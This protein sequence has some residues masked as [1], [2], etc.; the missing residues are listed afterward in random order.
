MSE[1]LEAKIKKEKG[2]KCTV[3]V[4]PE[5]VSI[6]TETPAD[7]YLAKSAIKGGVSVPIVRAL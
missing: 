5:Y 1:Q 2:V 4:K 7:F 3:L 6:K